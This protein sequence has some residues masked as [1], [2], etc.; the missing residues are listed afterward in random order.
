MGLRNRSHHD[1]DHVQPGLLAQAGDLIFSLRIVYL[2]HGT[3][4]IYDLASHGGGKAGRYLT[5]PSTYP[6]PSRVH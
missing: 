6:G 3:V 2:P 4:P 1:H 5:V